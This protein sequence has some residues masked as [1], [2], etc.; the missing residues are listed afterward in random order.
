MVSWTR[1][2]SGASGVTAG[3]ATGATRGACSWGTAEAMSGVDAM[4]VIT[5]PVS[6]AS[7]GVGPGNFRMTV[8]TAGLGCSAAISTSTSRLV[9]CRVA[10]ISSL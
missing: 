7:T 3:F 6:A 1:Y 2:F 9:L 10:A 4:P 8:G 5:V